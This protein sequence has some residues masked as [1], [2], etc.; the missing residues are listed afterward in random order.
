RSVSL[1]DDRL[2][3]S[4]RSPPANI[5]APSLTRISSV[6][7]RTLLLFLLLAALSLARAFAAAPGTNQDAPP[8]FDGIWNPATAT[9]LERPRQWKDKAF[10]T[11]EEA[12]EWERQVT[13]NNQE[14][15]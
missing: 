10:F 14:P 7:R 13:E 1:L 11:R 6:T 3:A 2:I 12:A 9:P 15:S 5:I 4:C 8:G